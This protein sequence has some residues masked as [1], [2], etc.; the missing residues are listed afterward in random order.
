MSS[1]PLREALAGLPVVTAEDRHALLSA[2]AMSC[3]HVALAQA[4]DPRERCGRRYDLAFLLTCLVAALLC[5]CNSTSAVGQ[6]CREHRALLRRVFGPRRHLTPSDSLYRRLLPR[7]SAD[8]LEWALAAWVRA[9]R[10]SEDT[11]PVAVDGKT[12][13]GAA[14]AEQAAPHLL[15]FCTHES[16]ETLPQAPVGE[17]TNELP[18]AHAWAPLSRGTVAW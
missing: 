3:L 16:Q 4:P 14:T 11:E 17:K 13:R 8:H 9:T 1:M 2:P 15:A 12:V 10:S 7:L 18:V 6:W 5:N